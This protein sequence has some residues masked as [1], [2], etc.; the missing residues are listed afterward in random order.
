MSP[1][2]TLQV[3]LAGGAALRHG[4]V[5]LEAARGAAHTKSTLVQQAAH[6]S[7]TL[8]EAC[9]GAQLARHDVNVEQVLLVLQTL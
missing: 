7:Y 9:L 2:H 1:H 4:Y 3:S 5:Q 8:T 6:S